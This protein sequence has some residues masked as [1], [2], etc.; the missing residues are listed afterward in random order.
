M[1]FKKIKVR[2]GTSDI[3]SNYFYLITMTEAKY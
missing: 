2:T 3:T 1:L